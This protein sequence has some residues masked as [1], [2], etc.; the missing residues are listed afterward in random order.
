MAGLAPSNDTFSSSDCVYT[1]PTIRSTL[2]IEHVTFLYVTPLSDSMIH[3]KFLLTKSENLLC[4]ICQ[5]LF[6]LLCFSMALCLA[7]KC[8]FLMA[9]SFGEC[10][11]PNWNCAYDKLRNRS[12]I[13]MSIVWLS[14]WED[15]TDYF[16]YLVKIPIIF[17]FVSH[18]HSHSQKDDCAQE[19]HF[20]YRWWTFWKCI[21]FHLKRHRKE[22]ISHKRANR[23]LP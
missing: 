19:F 5:S 20:L 21:E 1:S 18:G 7:R 16:V 14:L 11:L 9:S 17:I 4:P 12:S 10:F 6:S 15:Q 13:N 22:N 2:R 8:R 23:L 3:H